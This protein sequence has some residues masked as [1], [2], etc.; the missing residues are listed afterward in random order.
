[1]LV[2]INFSAFLV[3][4]SR[5]AVDTLLPEIILLTK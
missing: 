2:V 4:R 1:M 5:F 3:T